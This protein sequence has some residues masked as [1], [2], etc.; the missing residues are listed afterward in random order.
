MLTLLE[1]VR[2]IALE[3]K[4]VDTDKHSELFLLFEACQNLF[5]LP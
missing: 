5:M 1:D 3:N 4:C 2:N